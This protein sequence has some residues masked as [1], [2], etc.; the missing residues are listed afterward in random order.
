MIVWSTRAFR[1][2]PA[3]KLRYIPVP[4]EAMPRMRSPSA[5]DL[6]RILDEL[7]KGYAIGALIR[8]KEGT[9]LAV[10]HR[11]NRQAGPDEFL[12]EFILPMNL[13]PIVGPPVIWDAAAEC[14]P[15]GDV[16][17]KGGSLEQSI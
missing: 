15:H 13:L 5:D 11:D 3:G 6:G 7:P 14:N 8:I 10:Y 12:N 2:Y 17:P 4:A 16:W 1:N 9:F